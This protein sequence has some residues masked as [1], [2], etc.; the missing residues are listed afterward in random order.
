MATATVPN[1]LYKPGDDVPETGTYLAH[2]VG[3]HCSWPKAIL[4]TNREFPACPTCGDS[5]RYALGRN[6]ESAG[7]RNSP[8]GKSS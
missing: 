1:Y 7:S 5:V 2:H 4:E 8:F 6:A 3:I